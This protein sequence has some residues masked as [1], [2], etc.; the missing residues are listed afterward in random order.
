MTPGYESNLNRYNFIT[1]SVEGVIVLVW[2]SLFERQLDDLIDIHN[3]LALALLAS[4]FLVHL[5]AF[6]TTVG[7]WSGLLTVHAWSQHDEFLNHLLSFAGGAGVPLSAVLDV[8]HLSFVDILQ[9]NW[10]LSEFA[11]HFLGPGVALTTPTETEQTAQD[12]IHI[13]AASAAVLDSLQ[14]V[15]VVQLLLLWV[16]QDLIGFS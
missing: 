14:T 11:L 8:D 7:T 10:L 16:T 9:C 1:L 3:F 2:Y 15:L 12:I 6:S 5:H 13:T 4:I